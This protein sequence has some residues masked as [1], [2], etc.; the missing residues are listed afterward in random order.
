MTEIDTDKL[1]ERLRSA[2]MSNGRAMSSGEMLATMQV[3]G[4]A[5]L[6]MAAENKRLREALEP[7]P[8]DAWSEDFSDVLWHLM[9]I[10]EAPF[11][12]TPH[13]STWPYQGDDEP[14]L[15]WTPL[16]DCNEIHTRW[17]SRC[18]LGEDKA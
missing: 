6:A 15:W 17:E 7:R 18:A 4:T 2:Q 9:P 14:R 12:G 10:A 16:P 5:I 1:V 3:G 8:F 13:D 11:C